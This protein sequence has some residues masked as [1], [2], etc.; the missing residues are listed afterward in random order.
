LVARGLF[1]FRPFAGCSKLEPNLPVFVVSDRHARARHNHR[2]ANQIRIHGHHSH[3]FSPG[4][5]IVFHLLLP[6]DFTAR[7]QEF[8]MIA[9]AINIILMRAQEI[10]DSPRDIGRW[11]EYPALPVFKRT[12]DLLLER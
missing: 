8:L 5:R 6:V 4:R 1:Y 3:G 7:V 11:K 10:A 9:F 2:P 12:T